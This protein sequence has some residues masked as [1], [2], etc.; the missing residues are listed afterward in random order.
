M[1]KLEKIINWAN[2]KPGISTVILSG[3]LAGKG[4]K[5]ALSDY[6]IAV[7][8]TDFDFIKNDDWLRDIDD[9]AVCIHDSFEFS[10]YEIPTRLTIF[11]ETFK[12]DFSFHPIQAMHALIS[13]KK[14]PDAYNIGYQI[15]LDKEGIASKMQ[16]PTYQGFAVSKPSANEFEHNSKEFW[17][18]IYHVAKYLS[19][20][21]LWAAKSRD[22]AAK[23]W[24]RKMLEWY[25]AVK[26]NWTFSPKNEGKNM[27]EWMDEKIWKELH[28]TFGRFDRK[29]SWSSMEK[30]IKIYRKFAIKTATH[31]KYKYNTKTDDAIS[32]FI[33]KLKP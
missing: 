23:E 22:W 4:K 7:Y 27:K 19:R 16:K 2:N 29:D 5:D 8:G 6:D 30:T 1:Q 3:S 28:G 21:D 11:D 14:L 25:H 33:R 18:E 9:Y 26:M 12:I 32:G 13:Q 20:N 31:L 15:L 17:F 24:L 10:G